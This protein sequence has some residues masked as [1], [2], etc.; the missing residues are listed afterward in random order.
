MLVNPH[1]P[2]LGEDEGKE[3][4]TETLKEGCAEEDDLRAGRTRNHQF[5]LTGLIAGRFSSPAESPLSNEHESENQR[6]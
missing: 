5:D 3:K 6:A 1:S 4:R 2:K